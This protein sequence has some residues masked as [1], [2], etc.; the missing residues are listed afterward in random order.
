VR[1]RPKSRQARRHRENH[2][3]IGRLRDLLLDVITG[4]EQW[5]DWSAEQIAAAMD[6][7]RVVINPLVYAEVSVGYRTIE[8]LEDLFPASEQARMRSF[9][10]DWGVCS[11]GG[12]DLQNP[13]HRVV[14]EKIPG[15]LD[16]YI[17]LS[18]NIS[19]VFT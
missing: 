14:G 18:Y 17:W 8:E 11:Q 13:A 3:Q 2:S 16:T 4:D 19:V 1:T 6:V 10:G 7:G 5:A 9:W 12:H 15:N